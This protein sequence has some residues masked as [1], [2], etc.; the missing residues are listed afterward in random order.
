MKSLKRLFS[1]L[2]SDAIPARSTQASSAIGFRR[3]LNATVIR[4]C[5]KCGAP[6]VDQNNKY[7]GTICPQCGAKRKPPE[8]LGVVWKKFI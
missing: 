3:S 7:V 8:D 1:G 2:F 6:G 5:P 4:A